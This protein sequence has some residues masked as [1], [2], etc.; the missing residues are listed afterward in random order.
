MAILILLFA[1][2]S[3]YSIF[4]LRDPVQEDS[5]RISW[6]KT[7][8]TYGIL[9]GILTEAL[10]LNKSLNYAFSTVFWLLVSIINLTIIC[11]IIYYHKLYWLPSLKF[12]WRGL[13]RVNKVSLV[14]VLLVLAITLATSLIAAPNNWDSMTYHLP[15]VMHWIQNQSVH[16]YPTN[17]L[18]Q[19]DKFL[20]LQA[21]LILSRNFNY[22]LEQIAWLIVS[23][24]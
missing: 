16:Q 14:A 1:F 23:S 17:N 6:L 13:D 3:T 19:I 2:F 24:G 12:N 9:I 22:F 7:C 4:C 15:R 20:S 21:L 10:S 8:I 5:L 18:R 11:Y